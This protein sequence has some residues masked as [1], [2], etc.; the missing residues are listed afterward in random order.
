[1]RPVKVVLKSSTGA[2]GELSA[3]I[4]STMLQLLLLATALDSGK[5]TENQ[6]L[7][8]NFKILSNHLV[9]TAHFSVHMTY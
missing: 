6:D 9:M 7:L 4:Y 2:T 3:I 8:S 5:L 1:M